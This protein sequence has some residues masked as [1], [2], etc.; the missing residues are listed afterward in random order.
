MLSCVRDG[1]A[2]GRVKPRVRLDSSESRRTVVFVC[3]VRGRQRRLRKF[4]FYRGLHETTILA[5]HE[6]C[7]RA[8]VTARGLEKT[9]WGE[10]T[11]RSIVTDRKRE[12]RAVRNTRKSEIDEG[13]RSFL[14]LSLGFMGNSRRQRGSSRSHYCALVVAAV[15]RP[16]SRPWT[17][18]F[19]PVS[20]PATHRLN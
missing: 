8:R 16:L 13:R 18:R 19:Q 1:A 9:Q 5:R 14:T 10:T 4:V 20:G 15:F 7:G 12:T 6:G 11:V 17:S 2:F 3:R